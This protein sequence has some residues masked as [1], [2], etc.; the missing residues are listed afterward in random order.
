MPFLKSMDILLDT[1]VLMNFITG[2]ED[3]YRAACEKLMDLC[4][5]RSYIHL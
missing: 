1:N 5:P 4:S 3:P 2:R